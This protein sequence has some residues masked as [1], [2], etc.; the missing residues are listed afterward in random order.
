MSATAPYVMEAM[1]AMSFAAA[2]AEDYTRLPQID[3]YLVR[4]VGPTAWSTT[5]KKA[6][7]DADNN[8]IYVGRQSYT[9]QENRA[10]GQENDGRASYRYVAGGYYFNL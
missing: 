9:I 4:Q 8:W 6:Y 7:Y 3:V 10:Y 5:P 2:S 1:P